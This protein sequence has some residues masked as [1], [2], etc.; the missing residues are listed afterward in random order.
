MSYNKRWSLS[1][2]R[3]VVLSLLFILTV[4]VMALFLISAGLRCVDSNGCLR[5]H[6]S[7][8]FHKLQPQY[9]EII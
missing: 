3:D 7:P 8:F 5:E 1:Y 4:L 2:T 9:Q 6:C